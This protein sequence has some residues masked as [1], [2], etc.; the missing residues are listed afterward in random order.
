MNKT[1]R[2]LIVLVCCLIFTTARAQKDV[3][4]AEKIA[5][6]ALKESKNLTYE[7]NEDLMQNDFIH[8][9]GEYRKAISKSGAN[10]VAPY[11]LGRAYYNRESYTEAFGRFKQAGEKAAEKPVKHKA[12]HNMG[13]VF[14]KNKE[15]AK[16]VEAYKQSLRNNPNDDETR[17]NLAL[18]KE[19]LKNEQD[20]QQNDENKDDKQDQDQKD[21][22]EK[23]QDQNQEGD[24]EK[25]KE[26]DQDDKEN[27]DQGD[28]G[29]EG[30][31]KPEEN[32][33]GEG[34][35]KKEQKKKPNEGNTE[36]QKKKP[37]PNQLSKQ[38]IQNLLEAMQNEEKK[39]Q[40]KMEAKKVKGAKI[41][42]EKDW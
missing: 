24:N 35:E 26:G 4:T 29:G 3:E 10:A 23:N 19:L 37:R 15:Y 12:F 36:D 21:N 41:K 38:Q 31:E 20:Q 18:A 17:Y 6:K 8:A 28:Q 40:E 9:E 13:N 27:K 11:N 1:M 16:A 7:A 30:K 42:N 5:E 2:N 39:V 14:M 22:K 25:D 33:E 32:K 34:D